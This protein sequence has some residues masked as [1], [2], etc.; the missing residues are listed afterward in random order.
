M[1]YMDQTGLHSKTSAIKITVKGRVQGVGFRP[2]IFQIAS[3]FRVQGTVQNNMDGVHIVAEGERSSLEKFIDSIRTKAPRLSRIDVIEAVEVAPVGYEGFTIIPSERKG[4]SSLVIPIDSAV[5]PDCLREMRDCNNFRY[6][7]PFINC[8]QCG[9][10]YTIIDSLPY[11]RPYTTMSQFQMCPQCERE[12]EDPMNRRHHAQPI[13]CETCGPKVTLYSIDGEYVEEKDAAIGKAIHLLQQGKIMAIKGIGG[14]HLACDAYNEEAVSR[15]RI[16]KNRPQRPLAVM[17]ASMDAVNE[18]CYCSNDEEALV[19]SPES[20]IVILKKKEGKEL[21]DGLAP[22]MNTLGV[23][24][25]N[26]P[27]HHLLFAEEQLSVLVMTSANPSG[28]PMLYE[29]RDAFTYLGGI[30]DYILANNRPILHPVD[31]SVVQFV[32]GKL[33]FLRRSRGYVPDPMVTKND[34]HELIALGS[35]QKNTFAIGRNEQIFI[36]PHIGEMENLEVVEHFEKELHHLMKWMGIKGKSIAIDMH[37]GYMTTELAENMEGPIIPVQHHHA[38]LVS[39]MEDNKLTDPVFGIILDGTGY[40][41][42]GHIWGFEFL[43]GDANAYTRLAHLSYTPLPSNEKAVKEPWRN[44]VGMLIGYFGEEGRSFAKK[45]FVGRE[46]EIDIMA[47]ML[48]S[49]INSPLAGTCGRLFDAVS[50]IVG[51]CDVSTYDGEA[52]IKLSEQMVFEHNAKP[53]SY[54]IDFIEGLGEIS[55]APMLKEIIHEKLSGVPVQNIIHRFHETIVK[56]CVEV[57]STLSK[58]YPSFNKQVVLSGGSFH[59]RYLSVEISKR[60]QNQ[61]FQVYTH[62]RVPCNDG[63]LSLGQIIIAGKRMETLNKDAQIK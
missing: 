3:Q 48:K 58:Q 41:E 26:T 17:A 36:G 40:G 52:A 60:L 22:G 35:Q 25:P 51:V 33:A 1:V 30:A 12:Y 18:I 59:N 4:K 29:D 10:R 56:V 21:A 34:V 44:A 50:A 47:N 43:Y 15:L 8:T 27:L 24:L 57:I 16:R 14:Y 46:Y 61:G 11:D 6:Q 13:A 62:E 31:D 45:L 54:R 28:L 49:G 2:F 63:G 32:D 53:Y 42:D 55:F 7:Y 37:P 23:M 5:C 9:P 19:R 38:H 39:C 20:P